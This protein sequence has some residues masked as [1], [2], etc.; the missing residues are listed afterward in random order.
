MID[1]MINKIVYSG[2]AFLLVACTDL[3]TNPRQS[4]TPEVAL[5]DVSGYQ[6]VAN[7]MYNR[8][9]SFGYYGQT[10]MIAPEILAD[11]LK[12][13]ANTGRYQGEE[14]NSDREHIDIWGLDVFGGINDANLI[15]E[16]I[17]DEEVSGEE[18]EKSFIKGE[19]YFMRALFYFDLCRVYGYEPGKEVN[20][21][22]LGPIM[23]LTPTLVASEANEYLSRSTVEEVYEQ[24]ESDL[25]AAIPLVGYA[26]IGSDGVYYANTGAAL[27]LLARLYLYW[28]KMAEAEEAAS[29]AME[30]MGLLTNGEGLL[31]ADQYVQGF[32]RAPHPESLFEL[33]LRIVD[34]SDGNG[35][36]NSLNSLVADNEPA[37]QFIIGASD[38]L[39]AAYEEGDVRKNCWAATTRE[40]VEGD[41]YASRKW[42]GY[43]GDFLEN[44]PILRASELYLIR[45]EARYESNPS[46][47]RADL[48][49][50][51]SRRGLG[52]IDNLL[53]GEALLNRIL[54]ERR[55]EFA[56]EGHRW[57]DLKRN[58]KNISKPEG[59]LDVPYTDYRIL[60]NIPLDEITLNEKLEQNPGY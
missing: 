30:I 23:R 35:V 8:A 22:N 54:L 55:L 25:L 59:F 28:G 47:A 52:A 1:R 50:L 31:D 43:K 33:E 14:A 57:F 56:L 13:I 26:P 53:S 37:A 7:S 3:T 51:R 41:V 36:N 24:I 4:L 2:V 10:M 12:T 46:G 19:A 9:T 58:G 5:N 42:T 16:G 11:N 20:G 45:A 60:S 44:L 29:Y 27:T 18:D 32:S 6:S 15:I 48:N 34:W 38:D 40:G 39:M 49:A 17:D 21:F